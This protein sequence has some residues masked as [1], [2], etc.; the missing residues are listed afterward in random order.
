MCK[1][2]WILPEPAGE[3]SKGVCKYCGEEKTFPNSLSDDD[4]KR[5]F[6]VYVPLRPMD[7]N[8]EAILAR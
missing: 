5:Y 3:I 2:Y 1:H 4:Y 6:P 7:N 8:I